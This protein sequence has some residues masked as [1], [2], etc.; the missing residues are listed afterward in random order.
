MK[1]P[2]TARA[3]RVVAMT[4][5]SSSIR[6]VAKVVEGPIVIL[7]RAVHIILSP[8][9]VAKIVEMYN[10]GAALREKWQRQA[11]SDGTDEA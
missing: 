3:E 1:Q 6:L 11:I 8:Q 7:G 2:I 4:M 9:E 5:D 10:A